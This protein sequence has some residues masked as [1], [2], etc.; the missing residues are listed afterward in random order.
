MID[1]SGNGRNGTI[2]SDPAVP[3]TMDAYE[4]ILAPGGTGSA[5]PADATW[6]HSY[7]AAQATMT[8]TGWNINTEGTPSN[9]GGYATAGEQD[10]AACGR[11]RARSSRSA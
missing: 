7:L 8:G 9:L 5:T 2:I 3:P 1:S 4:V 6:L 11:A 10:V